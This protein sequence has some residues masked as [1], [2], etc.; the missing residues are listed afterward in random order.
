M[1]NNNDKIYT[2]L[3]LAQRAGKIVSGDDSTLMELKKNKVV[4]VIIASDASNN[5]K[6]TFVDKSTYRDVEYIEFSNKVELGYSI[7]KSPRAVI[8]IKD[9]SFANK[10]KEMIESN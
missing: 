4:L 1:S 8:G 6:K 5:T 7:G 3:G 10:I 2:F 9:K